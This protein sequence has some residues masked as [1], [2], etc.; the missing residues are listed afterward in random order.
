MVLAR[1]VG[2]YWRLMAWARSERR[3][4]GVRHGQHLYCG[5]LWG[6]WLGFLFSRQL[7][8]Y[9]NDHSGL[10]HAGHNWSRNCSSV[11]TTMCATSMRG[12]IYVEI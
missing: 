5:Y 11:V 3:Q 9:C 6:I 1:D 10:V 12:G 4:A 2:A 8:L 7:D